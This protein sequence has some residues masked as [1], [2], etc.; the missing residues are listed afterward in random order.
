MSILAIDFA[1]TAL[2]L[3][4]HGCDN[5]TEPWRVML[6]HWRDQATAVIPTVPCNSQASHDRH[7]EMVRH[8]ASRRGEEVCSRERM[9]E[10][11]QWRTDERRTAVTEEVRVCIHVSQLPIVVGQ[12]EHD[13]RD[14]GRPDSL[15]IVG[16]RGENPQPIRPAW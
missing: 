7:R 3:R 1:Y 11:E 2:N 10:S 12:R 5:E 9:H 13:T 4:G 14:R 16:W 8:C 6:A 15:L